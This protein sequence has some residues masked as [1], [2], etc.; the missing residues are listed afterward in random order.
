MLSH[1]LHI[2]TLEE[3]VVLI[4]NHYRMNLSRPH[5]GARIQL[6]DQPI[7]RSFLIDLY[8]KPNV[9]RKKERLGG[10]AG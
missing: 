3:A 10:R 7:L 9:A 4:Q 8:P 5:T 6:L 2:I 1:V